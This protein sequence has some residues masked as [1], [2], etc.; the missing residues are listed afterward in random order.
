[1]PSAV[2]HPQSMAG[3]R[4]TDERSVFKKK[5]NPGRER[6]GE[7]A[8]RRKYTGWASVAGVGL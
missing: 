1:M 7:T 8:R 2:S 5:T 4:Y 6:Q 3:R